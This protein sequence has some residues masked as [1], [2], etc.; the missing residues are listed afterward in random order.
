MSRLTLR[1]PVALVLCTSRPR[2]VRLRTATIQNIN[3]APVIA[4]QG[5]PLSMDRSIGHQ[6]RRRRARWQMQT[7]TPATS[8]A[9]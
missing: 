6:G 4:T 5:R 8:W 2:A 7:V 1:P 9:P 3:Q